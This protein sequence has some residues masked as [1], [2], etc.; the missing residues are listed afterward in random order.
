MVQQGMPLPALEK[1]SG[2]LW[3]LAKNVA[4]TNVPGTPKGFL[5]PAARIQQ[6]GAASKGAVGQVGGR[7]IGSAFGK[8]KAPGSVAWDLSRQ[9][10]QMGVV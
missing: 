4:M 6:F 9:A 5:A 3:D 1:E 8:P 7:A 2:A 10:R